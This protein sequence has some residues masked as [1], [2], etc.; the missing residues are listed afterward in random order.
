MPNS[1]QTVNNPRPHKC[2]MLGKK[3]HCFHLQTTGRFKKLA[4]LLK[5]SAISYSG[6]T[7]DKWA[8]V[9]LACFARSQIITITGIEVKT[10]AIKARA[11]DAPD[12]LHVWGIY[13]QNCESLEKKRNTPPDV[14]TPT[15]VNPATTCIS[16]K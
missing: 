7:S 13:A 9:S 8:N 12:I 5:T 14:D 6:A 3:Q 10:K 1:N 11:T 4:Q 15:K 16:T 2:I